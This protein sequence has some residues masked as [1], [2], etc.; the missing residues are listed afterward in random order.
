M[1]RQKIP[2]TRSNLIA[3]KNRLKL[4]QQGYELLNKKRD[5]LMMEIM[6]MIVDADEVQRQVNESFERAYG[7][8]EEA[9]VALG[10]EQIRRMALSSARDMDMRVTPR[11]IMGVVVPS[12]AFEMAEPRPKYGFGNSSVVLDDAQ[13][14][15]SDVLRLM[16]PLAEKV[17]TVWRLAIELQRTQR[18]VNALENVFIPSY[19][20]TLSYIEDTLAE[21]DREELFRAKRAKAR[22]E[23]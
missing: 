2:P 7:S 1:A 18:R 13:R 12:V 16:G 22:L 14:S 17:T 19:Q 23:A 9:R 20:E 5:V 15:W 10:T 21:K 6:R 4:A 3:I 8:I 11:S